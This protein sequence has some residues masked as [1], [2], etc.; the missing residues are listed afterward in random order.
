MVKKM[1]R[2]PE[3]FFSAWL[4]LTIVGFYLCSFLL[5]DG[6]HPHADS[7]AHNDG[8]EPH[9]HLILHSHSDLFPPVSARPEIETSDNE[10]HPPLGKPPLAAFSQSLN[11][12]QKFSDSKSSGYE[13]FVGAPSPGIF[14]PK[15]LAVLL[16]L[17][18]SP[19]E[20]IFL[21]ASSGR[22]PPLA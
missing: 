3:A 15:A 9:H 21:P 6:P 14:F 20:R 4:P 22:S 12:R 18:E 11:K 1:R 13:P 10:H 16:P 8:A 19:P 2:R 5:T 7:H 17:D